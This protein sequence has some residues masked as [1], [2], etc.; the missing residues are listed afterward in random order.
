M[1]QNKTGA[2]ERAR[3]SME[4]YSRLEARISSLQLPESNKVLAAVHR[5]EINRRL[6]EWRRKGVGLGAEILMLLG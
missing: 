2:V 1:A 5:A 3:V 4:R 6:S